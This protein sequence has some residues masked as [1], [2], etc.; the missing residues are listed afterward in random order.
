MRRTLGPAV[1]A[2]ALV[3]APAAAPAACRRADGPRYDARIVAHVDRHR[4]TRATLVVCDRRRGRSRVL[5]RAVYRY[6]PEHGTSLDDAQAAGRR[7]AWIAG[8]FRGGR[9]T[10]T[11]TVA[12]AR[13]G[14]R[15]RRRTVA[16]WSEQHVRPD[17]SVALTTRGELAWLGPAPG[18]PRVSQV[19]LARP[20]LAPRVIAQGAYLYSLG[21]EDDRTLRWRGATPLLS[22]SDIRASG[23]GCPHRARFKTLALL[24][25]LVA[26]RAVYGD[27]DDSMD[28]VRVCDVLTGRDPVVGVGSYTW[29]SGDETSVIGGHAPWVVLERRGVSRYDGCA[30]DAVAVV[31]VRAGA[32]SEASRYADA[33]R[34]DSERR[35]SVA[36]TDAGAAAWVGDLGGEQRIA[37]VAAGGGIVELDRAPAGS[38]GAL[39]V[40]GEAFAWTRDGQA[41]SAAAP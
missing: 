13:T 1:V 31:N 35:T 14:R 15:L 20:G 23:A 8:A 4:V 25:G 38:L 7:V 9:R 37:A 39:H 18:D 29:G 12:D 21:I 2:L 32:G 34:C 28:A 3:A 19:T 30:D 22:Y 11:V 40:E 41:R 27:E 36:V 5:A 6:G 17:L 10:A 16:S 26:T 24:D 33:G